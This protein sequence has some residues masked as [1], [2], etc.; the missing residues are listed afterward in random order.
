MGL[1]RKTATEFSFLLAVP[2]MLAATGYDL[3]KSVN[4]FSNDDIVTLIIGF[5]L[6]FIFAVLAVKLFIS[7]IQTHDFKTFGV[8]RIVLSILFW[9]FVK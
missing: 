4:L 3:Y 1:N 8:Y 6:A 9:I 7:Y 5:T 2:T